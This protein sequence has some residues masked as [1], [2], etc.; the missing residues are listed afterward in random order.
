VSSCFETRIL[1]SSSRK[2]FAC[3]IL[4]IDWLLLV[5]SITVLACSLQD[6]AALDTDPEARAG[7]LKPQ[8]GRP[9]AA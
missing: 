7:A 9:S 3:A 4:Y 5:V 2:V 8:A 6:C 1:G